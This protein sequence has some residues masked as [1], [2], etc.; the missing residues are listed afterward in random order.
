[1]DKPTKSEDGNEAEHSILD[2]ED[3][4]IVL[5]SVLLQVLELFKSYVYGLWCFL[6]SPK[7]LSAN[8]TKKHVAARHETVGPLTFL[9]ICWLLAALI[10]SSV[11]APLDRWFG[12]PW[13]GVISWYMLVKPPNLGAFEFWKI[14]FAALPP[15]FTCAWMALCTTWAAKRLKITSTFSVHLGICSYFFGMLALGNILGVLSVSISD[16]GLISTDT[17]EEIAGGHMTQASFMAIF[18]I[19]Y[20]SAWTAVLYVY[21]ALFNCFRACLNAPR[22]KVIVLVFVVHASFYPI[23]KCLQIGNAASQVFS[24]AKN[25]APHSPDSQTKQPSHPHE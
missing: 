4:R 23:D 2:K 9:V 8:L 1:M 15:L 13:N 17:P 18:Y 22:W 6:F 16:L 19:F 11:P 21:Y 24:D 10:K 7:T 3:L 5:E 20:W 12:D 14:V 25:P